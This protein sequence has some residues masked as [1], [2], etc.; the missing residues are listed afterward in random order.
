MTTTVGTTSTVACFAEIT[1]PFG[2]ITS[3]EKKPIKTWRACCLE[4][5]SSYQ[6]KEE[7]T[8]SKNIQ[9]SWTRSV[10][11]NW[12]VFGVTVCVGASTPHM[13]QSDASAANRQVFSTSLPLGVKVCPSTRWIPWSER[14]FG[15]FF[16][17][18]TNPKM[19]NE[20]KTNTNSYQLHPFNNYWGMILILI[21]MKHVKL[22]HF[23]CSTK[24]YSQQHYLQTYSKH[25]FI[26]S[27]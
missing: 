19:G 27:P 22:S 12:L 9:I 4:K 11:L 18:K 26:R 21:L 24:F 5:G 15:H 10:V 13:K 6:E 20:D 16:N 23:P 14:S 25:T 17:Q 1:K 3:T 2:K 8:N 7:E